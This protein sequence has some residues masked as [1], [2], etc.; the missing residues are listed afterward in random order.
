MMVLPEKDIRG[1]VIPKQQA[2]S[3]KNLQP[4]KFQRETA[5]KRRQGFCLGESGFMPPAFAVLYSP[6]EIAR[7]AGVPVR[8]VHAILGAATHRTFVPH[9]EAVRL[10]RLLVA[11]AQAPGAPTP[12]F[13]AVSRGTTTR[14]PL[15]P[16]ALSSS[17]H[18]GLAVALVIAGLN[19]APRAAALRLDDRPA[20]L[21]RLVFL[22]SPGPGGGGGGGGLQQRTPPPK[23]MRE[24][25]RRISSPLPARQEPKPIVPAPD[26][27]EPK[28]APPLKAEQLPVVVAPIVTAPA[29]PRTRIGVLEE[30]TAQT[31][32]NGPGK[33]GGA[34]T[35]A[36]VGLGAGDGSG[37]GPGSG[38]GTGGGP[39]RPGSGIQPP[40]LLREVKAA[41]TEDARQKGIAGDVVL[42]IVVRRDGSVGDVRILQGLG[43]GLNDRAVRAVRQWTFAP[44]QRLGAAVDVIV[45]VAVE[46]SLR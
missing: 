31:D 29:D 41:Y 34:G 39:Y 40:R 20:D 43:G 11:Q 45:E 7:A 15:M 18:A 12:M 32:A 2:A 25:T 36:G 16:L 14:R 24:G 9:D 17:L 10:G 8:E 33:G 28:P 42:E 1:S 6:R 35:G 19:I 26:P 38:G 37:V 22:Q 21:M 3:S 30:T 27:P 46:F 5:E 44:A 13:A 23:A 4:A